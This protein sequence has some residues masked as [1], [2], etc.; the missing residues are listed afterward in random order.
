MGLIGLTGVAQGFDLQGHR[1]AR[2]L[3]PE[4]TLPGFAK[5]LSIGVSTLELDLAVTR[6]F[7]VVVIHDPRFEPKIARAIKA[8]GGAIWSSYHREV[9]VNSIELAHELETL[10]RDTMR[11]IHESCVEYG[12]RDGHVDYLAGANIAGFVKV[13]DAMLSFGHT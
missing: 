6:D 1:G 4:N 7:Q 5:A 10:L 11:N 2:G 8:A 9:S 3:M 12:E 13:A